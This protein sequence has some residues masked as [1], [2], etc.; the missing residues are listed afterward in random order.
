MKSGYPE[1]LLNLLTLGKHSLS[2]V[3]VSGAADTWFN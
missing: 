2:N 3:I 1:T